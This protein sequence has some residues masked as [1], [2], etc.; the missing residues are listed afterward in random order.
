MCSNT[1]LDSEKDTIYLLQQLAS[2]GHKVSKDKLHFCLPI[3]KYLIHLISKDGPLIDSERIKRIL[4]FTLPKTKKQ[5]RGFLG[6]TG[7]C[8][9][10]VPNIS[11]IAQ[12]LYT[13]LKSDQ[14][15]LIVWTPEGE[16]AATTLKSVL[17]QAQALGHPNYSLPFFFFIYEDKG[18]PLGIVTQKHEGRHRPIGYYS[19]QLDSVAKGLPPCMRAISVTAHLCKTTEEI[20]MGSPLTIYV[21]HSVKSLLNSHHTQ[22]YSVSRLASYE[23]LLFS[24]P[25]ITLALCNNLT[26]AT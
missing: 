21:P 15:D 12:P 8:R 13:L 6:L 17:A 16:K 7:Y 10:W 9:N 1:K 4:A 3:V 22:H 14:P 25:N 19:Q 2:K 11:L 5:L 24:A 18:N 20:L 26:P 23:V